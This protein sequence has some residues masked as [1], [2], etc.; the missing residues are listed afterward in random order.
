MRLSSSAIPSAVLFVI[1]AACAEGLP[2]SPSESAD[3]PEGGLEGGMPPPM[4]GGPPPMEDSG[5]MPMMDAGMDTAMVDPCMDGEKNGLETDTDC[6]GP[7]CDP[8]GG[9]ESCVVPTD[10]E[11]R[12]CDAMNAC[13]MPVPDGGMGGDPCMTLT[14]PEATGCMCKANAGKAYF[15]CAGPKTFADARTACMAAMSDLVAIEDM[16]EQTF[17]EPNVTK[18]SWIGAANSGTAPNITWMWVATGAMFWSGTAAVG[19]AYTNWQAGHPVAV[20]GWCAMM[21]MT[22]HTWVTM[23]CMPLTTGYICEQK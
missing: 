7:K 22:A 6:G 9:G 11:S 2:S 23:A 5:S 20:P 16:A 21:Q 10:C 1:L 12:M 15:F 19:G 8:C 4:E 18:N 17:L 13:T 14:P 3:L